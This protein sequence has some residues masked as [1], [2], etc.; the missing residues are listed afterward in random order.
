[1]C[2]SDS[3]CIVQST[4]DVCDKAENKTASP[5]VSAIKVSWAAYT[6]F[7]VCSTHARLAHYYSFSFLW[8]NSSGIGTILSQ[9]GGW[10]SFQ[11][12]WWKVGSDVAERSSGKLRALGK[13][14]SNSDVGREFKC[15]ENQR[16]RENGA[17]LKQKGGRANERS[18][19]AKKEAR[20]KVGSWAGAKQGQT[21]RR[22]QL[23]GAGVLKPKR[24]SFDWQ[25]IGSFFLMNGIA[26]KMAPSQT[27][28]SED[29]GLQEGL[30]IWQGWMLYKHR[31]EETLFMLGQTKIWDQNIRMMWGVWKS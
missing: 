30:P 23:G 2:R 18:S 28:L 3:K 25:M 12:S 7:S 9:F 10:E 19:Q 31:T 11:E 17:G 21:Q 22:K 13:L 4:Q 26:S 6:F 1:M 27:L 24:D 29:L 14:V 8:S 5:I 16:C 20:N 15:K